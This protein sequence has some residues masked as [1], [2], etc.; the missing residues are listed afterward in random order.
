MSGSPFLIY[1]P[2][3][4]GT[5]AQ[6]IEFRA[7]GFV[8]LRH[9]VSTGATVFGASQRNYIR[10]RGF[11]VNE[12]TATPRIGLGPVALW[13]TTGSE[14]HE[15]DLRGTNPAWGDNHNGIRVEDSFDCI[16][17][18]NRIDGFRDGN[19]HNGAGII[20][21]DSQRITVEHNEIMNCHAGVFVKGQ[22]DR[23]Q[24]SWVIRNNYIH[25]NIGMGVLLHGCS[26]A[27]VYRNIIRTGR[28]GVE[29]LAAPDPVVLNSRV[30]NNTIY[31]MRDGFGFGAA[32]HAGAPGLGVTPLDNNTVANNIVMDADYMVFADTATDAQMQDLTNI[33]F[34]H[35]LYHQFTNAANINFGNRNLA[36][37]LAYGQ[38]SNAVPSVFDN[39]DFMNAAAFDF[40]LRVGSPALNAGRDVLN[41]LGGGTTAPCNMG[42][43]LVGD[44]VIGIQP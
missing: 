43:Y 12:T 33:L 41:L 40:H 3:N 32:F 30:V 35:N 11:Y 23:V 22:V 28:G 37:W 31:N 19:S 15:C 38:D 44:E 10:W 29:F 25:N 20:A 21:Y 39:P 42:A 16:V 8:D 1:Q 36:A 6:P 9:T 34:K 18:N 24:N 13:H 14:I 26:G 7:N 27:D 2:A 5:A 17:R 4:S